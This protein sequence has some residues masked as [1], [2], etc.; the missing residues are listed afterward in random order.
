MDGRTDDGM[1]LIK[2]N[3]FLITNMKMRFKT[4]QNTLLIKVS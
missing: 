1:K 3:K 2:I 4:K